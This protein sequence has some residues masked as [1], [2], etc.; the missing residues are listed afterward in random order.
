MEQT[1][2]TGPLLLCCYVQVW[3][4][5]PVLLGFTAPTKEFEYS[6]MLRKTGLSEPKNCTFQKR[7]RDH[8]LALGVLCF[9]CQSSLHEPFCL[10]VCLESFSQ[11]VTLQL[12][13]RSSKLEMNIRSC[14]RPCLAHSEAG[15]VTDVTHKSGEVEW[16]ISAILCLTVN[17]SSSLSSKKNNL[18]CCAMR[19]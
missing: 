19:T 12:S 3:D 18:S 6:N 7:H 17:H 16:L 9:F 2:A 5:H 14:K 4:E 8:P 13:L 11:D 1:L 15:D 10:T